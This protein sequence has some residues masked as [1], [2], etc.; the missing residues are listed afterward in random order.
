MHE[1]TVQ[2]EFAAAH[3]IVIGGAHEPVHGHNWRVRATVAGDRLDAEG[4]LCDFHL[5]ENSLR[6]VLAPLHNRHLNEI[7]PFDRVN[8][9]A[10]RVAMHIAERLCQL[11][12]GRLPAGVRVARVAVTEAPGCEAAYLPGVAP[13]APIADR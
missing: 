10:E 13:A 5:I 11:T 1:L 7:A 9:T 8:P 4:L 3:A 12:A 6:E 2:S